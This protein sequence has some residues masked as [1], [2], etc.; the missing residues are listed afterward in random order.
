LLH[1]NEIEGTLVTLSLAIG[2]RPVF[3]AAIM[4]DAVISP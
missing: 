4:V 3:V 2:N 1:V